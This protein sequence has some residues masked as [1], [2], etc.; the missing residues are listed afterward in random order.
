MIS[1][2][3]RCFSKRLSVMIDE[4]VKAL[5]MMRQIPEIYHSR[6]RAVPESAMS[7]NDMNRKIIEK[8]ARKQR[9]AVI[10]AQIFRFF[11]T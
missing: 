4:S 2:V 6:C 9:T 5:S 1:L 7:D 8:T 10:D 3:L 11:M